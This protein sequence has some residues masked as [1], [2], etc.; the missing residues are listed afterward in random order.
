[1]GGSAAASRLKVWHAL[2]LLPLAAVAFWI[3]E[4][5]RTLREDPA[6]VLR[7]LKTVQAPSLPEAAAAGANERT[8]IERY[9][10]DTLYDYIDG[11]AEAMIKR[12]FERCAVATYALAGGAPGRLEIAAEVYRFA[13]ADGARQQLDADRPSAAQPSERL[14]GALT[15]GTVL[16]LVSGRDFLKLTSL[17]RGLNASSPMLQ[18]ATAWQKDQPR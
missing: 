17:G 5:G 6:D 9:D 8:A 3:V 15:D 7:H 1:M 10:R 11:A 14:P 4:R 12:G 13:A 18:V 16:L 2:L